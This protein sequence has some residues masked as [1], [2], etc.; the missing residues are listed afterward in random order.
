MAQDFS[1]CSLVLSSWSMLWAVLYAGLTYSLNEDVGSCNVSTINVD[2]HTSPDV[3]ISPDG[4]HVNLQNPTSFFIPPNLTWAYEGKVIFIFY[5]FLF[6]S[7]ILVLNYF[8]LISNFTL[9]RNRI[10]W[11][12]SL[13]IYEISKILISKL[14][15]LYLLI[16]IPS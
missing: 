10:R 12:F 13:L 9:Y 2:G 7:H 5:C 8:V 1:Y 3:V 15:L 11:P 14:K 4:S 16:T 6:H